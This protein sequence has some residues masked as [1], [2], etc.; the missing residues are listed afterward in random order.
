LAN[1]SSDYTVDRRSLS[2]LRFL[3]EMMLQEI[4]ETISVVLKA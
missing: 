1:F 3:K 2:A 4:V